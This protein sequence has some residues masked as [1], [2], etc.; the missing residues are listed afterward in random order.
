MMIIEEDVKSLNKKIIIYLRMFELDGYL[1]YQE[2]EIISN[3]NLVPIG[4]IA[5]T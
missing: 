2:Y 4:F 5:I 1:R 3:S